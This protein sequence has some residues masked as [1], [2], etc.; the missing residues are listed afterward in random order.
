M[1][2]TKVVTQKGFKSIE[3]IRSNDIV[4]SWNEKTKTMEY[5]LVLDTYVRQAEAIYKIR[6]S[7]NRLIETTDTHPFYIVGGSTGSPTG[8]WVEAKDLK[9]GDRSAL[10]ND[11]TLAIASI[12]I[13]RRTETVY[14]F[15]VENAHTYFVTEDAVL[16]HNA[17]RSYAVVFQNSKSEIQTISGD[18]L[19]K[20]K[21]IEK[22]Y[23]VKF[24]ANGKLVKD[25][26]F[27]G[28]GEVDP[29]V[30]KKVHEKML[31]VVGPNDKLAKSMAVNNYDENSKTTSVYG[32]KYKMVGD[33]PSMTSFNA[34][35]KTNGKVWNSTSQAARQVG[36]TQ[37]DVS[38]IDYG[39]T[40]AHSRR[41]AIDVN[42]IYNKNG[43]KISMKKEEAGKGW[44]ESS[45]PK[46][47][48]DFSTTFVQNNVAAG[49][50]KSA[51][52]NPWSMHGY[53]FKA[54]GEPNRLH[55]LSRDD[56]KNPDK[57]NDFKTIHSGENYPKHSNHLHLS[58]E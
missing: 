29:E 22:Q 15:Q 21:D 19:D 36:I 41:N 39:G 10:S 42:A 6:Y 35:E 51:A 30:A 40:G 20:M 37:L 2:G 4:L 56:W 27:G 18:K 14:N 11:L 50:S 44:K 8:K 58:S 16:V 9:V 38:A 46:L 54:E 13:D 5:N 57:A 31:D 32:V 49:N 25:G 12:E 24:D 55:E 23:G 17:D 47:A 45:Y 28:G 34:I 3:E 26:F 33:P 43:D 1:A 48:K 53:G 52:W 7:N